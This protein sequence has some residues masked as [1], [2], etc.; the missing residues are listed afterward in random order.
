MIAPILEVTSCYYSNHLD[1][2][3]AWKSLVALCLCVWLKLKHAFSTRSSP[4]L[5]CLSPT[6]NTFISS[7]KSVCP[8]HKM[9]SSLAINMFVCSVICIR[10]W[11]AETI[12]SLAI[13]RFVCSVKSYSEVGSRDCLVISDKHVLLFEVD[14]ETPQKEQK[15]REK[16]QK[17]NSFQVTPGLI[18]R[19]ETR[20]G[21]ENSKHYATTECWHP[22][23]WPPTQCICIPSSL[24]TQQSELAMQ[25]HCVG[26][27]K[28]GRH[29]S[30]VG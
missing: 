24:C 2:N 13:D 22:P 8:Q 19:T 12:L 14:L 15:S 3:P 4:V 18:S 7:A 6:W 10:R 17:K 29:H 30:V 11:T 9:H 20:Q 5:M 21:W 23:L 1:I 25:V 27:Q 28:G 16:F 26:G